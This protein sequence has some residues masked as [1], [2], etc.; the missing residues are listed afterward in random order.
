MAPK[1]SNTAAA[2]TV[3][4]QTE[5]LKKAA[6]ETAAAEMAAAA[7]DK[8]AKPKATK[9]KKAAAVVETASEVESDAETK[10]AV[11]EKEKRAPN[12]Y[13]LFRKA[14]LEELRNEYDD[15]ETRPSYQDLMKMINEA[16]RE[17]HPKVEKTTTP[18]VKKERK[19]KAEKVEGEEKKKRAPSAYNIFIKE[20]MPKIKS[21]HENDDPKL[22][23][24]DIMKLAATAWNEHKAKNAA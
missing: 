8:A 21:E 12:A 14:K 15:E 7:V 20:I 23:Q 13:M 24:K 3:A 11:A 1:K 17:D 6:E 18:R 19:P 22:N 10:P 16:W 5:K 2:A 9:G 4:K